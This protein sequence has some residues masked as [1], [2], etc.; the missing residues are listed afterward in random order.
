MLLYRENEI[1]QEYVYEDESEFENDIIE[2]S[3]LL[4]GRDSVMIDTKKKVEAKAIGG[5]I[6]DGFLFDFSDRESPE[7]YLVEV[8][9]YK[10][11]F[12][13]HIFPQVTKFFA[14]FKNDKS[15][16][17][18]VEKIFSIINNSPDLRK[19]F[20]KYLGE[21]EIYKTIKDTIENS[22]NILLIIDDEKEELPE[23][24]D[25]Y[26]DTWGKM[27]RLMIV[28]KFYNGK[29]N[30]FSVS[31]E[32]ENL[33]LA[34]VKSVDSDIPDTQRTYT[35]EYHLEGVNDTVKAIYNQIKTSLLEYNSDIIFNPQKYYIS[36]RTSR[37]VAFIQIRKKK[38]SIVIMLPED[39]IKENVQHYRV[40]KLSEPIQKFYNGPCA[41]V[42]LENVDNID[43]VIETIKL[44]LEKHN[45]A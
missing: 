38:V 14:F 6:P 20:K 42:I 35:E 19:E 28:K 43:E 29:E 4:F 41:A 12:F 13:K 16:S 37:N 40:K 34:E 9:L 21:R 18:L 15:Q 25:T 11:D 32:F 36:I 24:I 3:K 7:F 22:Q 5:T 39:E 1:F 27:V 10:H 31:P 26:A 30:I 23:I 2:R 44:A 8:E 33:E 17:E 45:G